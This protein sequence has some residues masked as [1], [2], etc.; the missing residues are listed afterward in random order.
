MSNKKI[1]IELWKKIDDNQAECLNGGE[2]KIY[3]AGQVQ[4][5]QCSGD[6]RTQVNYFSPTEVS[7]Y[8]GYYS[9]KYGYG[10]GYGCYRHYHSS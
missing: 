7:S 10:Y 2:M 5:Y 6:N 9:H 4:A 1:N 3:I 8:Y